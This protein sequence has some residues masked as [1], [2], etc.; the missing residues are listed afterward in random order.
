MVDSSWAMG[1]GM[2]MGLLVVVVALMLETRKHEA[3]DETRLF[4]F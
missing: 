2:G 4:F 1:M 3:H